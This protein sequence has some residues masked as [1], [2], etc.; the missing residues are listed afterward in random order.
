[1]NAIERYIYQKTF[2]A[3]DRKEIYDS[4]MSYQLD[5]LSAEETFDKLI[6]NYTRRGKKPNNPI[7]KI[8]RECKSNLAIGSTVAQSFSE[9]LPEEELS[10]IISCE[11][12]GNLIK[13]FENAITIANGMIK[14]KNAKNN[15][16]NTFLYMLSLSLGLIIM[17]CVTMVPAVIQFVPLDKWTGSQLFLWYIYVVVRDFWY[18]ILG[19]VILSGYLLVKSFSRWTGKL[20]NVADNYFPYSVYKRINGAVFILNMNSM[21]TADIS[22][23]EAIENLIENCQS[24]WLLERLEAVQSAIAHGEK[25]LGSALNS[26]G[27]DYPGEQAIIKMQ[28]L[29]DTKN[30]TRSMDR[31]AVEWLNKTVTSLEALSG[32]VRLMSMFFCGGSVMYLVS[33]MADLI[34]NITN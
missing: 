25:N 23:E 3:N 31:F 28:S 18:V 16:R 11:K 1:M 9:W 21:L 26:T 15:A 22:M 27:Y 19:G 20:R 2:N 4:F 29:F 5:G 33:V 34:Q 30:G 17:F 32:T 12:A 14:L 13:G 6:L 8:L 24:A 7:A 10:I